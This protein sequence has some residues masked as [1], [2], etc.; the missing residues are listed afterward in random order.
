VRQAATSLQVHRFTLDPEARYHFARRLYAFARVGVGGAILASSLYDPVS[1]AERSQHPLK[2]TF[3]TSVGGA[4]EVLGQQSGSAR[5]TRG[6]L[7]LDA[8]YL[9]TSS[10][11]LVYESGS[12]SP[13]RTEPI[14]LGELALRGVSG[15]LSVAVTF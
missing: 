2:F 9:F 15:R 13:V 7:V 12:G 8:G 10:T 11:E 4:V 3:D 6:W 5:G 14:A 1:G